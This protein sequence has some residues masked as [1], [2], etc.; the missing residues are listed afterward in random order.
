MPIRITIDVENITGSV[1]DPDFAR[2]LEPLLNALSE[3]NTKA[4]FFIVG[5]LAPVWQ[6][7]IRMLS[8]AGHEIGLHGYTH[9]FLSEIGSHKFHKELVDGKNTLEDVLGKEVKGFRAPYF[10]LTRQT[11]WA[12]EIILE[13]GFSYS[14]SVLPAWN[15]QAGFPGAPREP[16]LWKCGLIEFPVPTFG[17]G[18]IRL[19]LLGG[20]YLRLIP[21]PV[22][23][24]ARFIGKHREGEWAYC[25]PY[26]FDIEAKFEKIRESSWIF[27]KLIFLRRHLMLERVLSLGGGGIAFDEL[28]NDNEFNSQLKIFIP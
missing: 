22:L 14:S 21:D 12:P 2:S 5:S 18:P 28:V 24:L 6:N 4:T 20:A 25:H 23:R 9:E 16:F 11:L 26:D 17:I 19:P 7:E 10:S 13:N 8:Y 3:T 15:P 27:S 1:T